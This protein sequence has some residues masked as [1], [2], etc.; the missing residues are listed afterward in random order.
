M[1]FLF[2]VPNLSFFQRIIKR[3]L[4]VKLGVWIQIFNFLGGGGASNLSYGGKL[5]HF[6]GSGGHKN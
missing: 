4:N 2:L 1:T 6:L 3:I 5:V